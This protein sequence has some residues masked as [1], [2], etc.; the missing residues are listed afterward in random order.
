[1]TRFR[2]HR[3]SLAD[4]MA[5][6]TTVDTLEQLIA[7]IEAYWADSGLAWSL[8]RDGPLRFE[9]CGYDDRIAWDTW[10]VCDSHGVIGM[11]DGNLS[12]G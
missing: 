10:Y 5:T 7:H 3:G 1:M 11:S 8:E 2:F 4:A 9:Y 12:I 6:V